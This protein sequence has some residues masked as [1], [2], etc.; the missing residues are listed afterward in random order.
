MFYVFDRVENIVWKGE[1]A[2]YFQKAP[3]SGPLQV[4]MC[5]ERG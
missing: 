2:G 3:S 5:M 1:N 4:G